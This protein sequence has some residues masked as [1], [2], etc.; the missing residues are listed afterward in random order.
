M[1]SV[2]AGPLSSGLFVLALVAFLIGAIEGAFRP[3]VLASLVAGGFVAAGLWARHRRASHP[4]I[5]RHAG[6]PGASGQ[7]TEPREPGE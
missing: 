2:A 7:P 1:R 5:S 6:P 4:S 3:F